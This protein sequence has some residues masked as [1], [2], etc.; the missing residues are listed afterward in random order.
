MNRPYAYTPYI[1]PL[2]ASAIFM[3][4]LAL[5]AWR[6]R[7]V[8]GARAFVV[9]VGLAALCSVFTAMEVTAS[10]ELIKIEWYKL[11]LIA[12]LATM[13][14]LLGFA[15]EHSNPDEWTTRL[16]VLLLAVVPLG[17]G[18]LIA[19]NDLHHLV[20]TRLWFDGFVHVERG[21]LNLV[22]L[23]CGLLMVL[24]AILV[25]VRLSLESGGVYRQQALA[26]LTAGTVPVL[27]FF[28]EPASAFLGA[29]LYAVI[30]MFNVS[31]LLFAIAIF[32]FGM[33]SV[34]PVGR[35]TAVERMADGTLTLDAENRVVDLNPAAGEMLGLCRSA[36]VGHPAGHVLAARPELLR[37]LEQES[38]AG[39]EIVSDVGGRSR[40]YQVHVSPLLGRNGFKL[41]RLMWLYDVTEQKQARE[42]LAQE[43]RG[44]A[45]LQERERLARELHDGLAQTLAAAHL[46]AHTAKLLL[47]QGETAQTEEC[48][49]QLGDMTLQAEADVRE[50]LLGVQTVLAG[51][52]PFFP[53]VRQYLDRF[54]QRYGL[55]VDLSVEPEIEE[56]GLNPAAEWQL[57][58]LIQ[59]ALAN[60]RKHAH[61]QC[62]EVSF[63][64]VGQQAR[65]I[66]ADDGEGFDPAAA[67]AQGDGFGLVAMRERAEEAGGSLKV[68]SSPGQGTRVVVKVPLRDKM[69]L[70]RP[71]AG[72]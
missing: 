51:E 17:G 37:L 5:Y 32:R 7:R 55:H 46:Q 25:F 41:G 29:P 48:L 53:S 56:R 58:R 57:L 31:G 69:P 72:R 70:K 23:G 21:P 65:I 28:V 2:L 45:I 1:W 10:D 19:T 39:T 33:L 22:L 11:E 50:Y 61:A 68:I 71:G 18:G 66:I 52:H 26:F 30:L 49:D 34:V 60:V 27:A 8:P 3:A 4:G 13:T 63:A 24:L 20:W 40:S 44:R 67:A 36:A 6:H 64:V 42:L 43:Q 47:T 14:A 16:K 35:D 38:P 15:L 9:L 12:A 59:E 62:A 54:H